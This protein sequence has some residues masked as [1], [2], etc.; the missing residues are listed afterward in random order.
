M[1]KKIKNPKKSKN[2]SKNPC[3][4]AKNKKSIKTK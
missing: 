1:A 4:I 3:K 2:P